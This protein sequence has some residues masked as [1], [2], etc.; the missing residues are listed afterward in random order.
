MQA[1]R[2]SAQRSRERK[3]KKDAKLRDE[4]EVL[5]DQIG[6]LEAK[7]KNLLGFEEGESRSCHHLPL[8]ASKHY[9]QGNALRSQDRFAQGS[10]LHQD[11]SAA[12]L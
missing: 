8:S 1:N 5:N 2:L 7:E 4:V 3:L 6:G 9:C 12:V 11:C 10:A